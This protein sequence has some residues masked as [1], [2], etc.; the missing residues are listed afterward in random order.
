MF[1]QPLT[2]DANGVA[3]F[4]W[5]GQAADGELQPAGIYR[6]AAQGTRDGQAVALDTRTVA[7]VASV[8]LGSGGSAM[9]LNLAGLGSINADAILEIR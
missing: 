5:N 4:E 6:F 2:T 3:N 9:S 1:Q 7:A 8:T